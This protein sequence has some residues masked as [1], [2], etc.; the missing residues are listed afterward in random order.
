MVNK[1]KIFDLFDHHPKV[2][3][4][5]EQNATLLKEDPFTKIGMF[6]KLIVNHSIFHQKLDK[7]LKKEH[8]SYDVE[9]TKNA[10]MFTVYNRAWHYISQ[11]DLNNKYHL[12]ALL[13]F[14]MEPFITTLDQALQYFESTEEYERC[15]QLLKIKKLKEA[16]KNN[17]AI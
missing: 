7:F 13:D 16:F 8:P 4:E 5:I 15:A 6:T 1:N 9:T 17:L 3:E 10:S 14:K 2:K 12:N 11:I